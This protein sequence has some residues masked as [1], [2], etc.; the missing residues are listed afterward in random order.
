MPG[1]STAW[2]SGWPLLIFGTGWMLQACER[3]SERQ[4]PAQAKRVVSAASASARAVPT[5]A[6]GTSAPVAD[7]S[8]DGHI[9][10]ARS[11]EEPG[12]DEPMAPAAT[13]AALLELALAGLPPA[14]RPLT[15]EDTAFLK[16]AIGPGSFGSM[17]QGNPKIAKHTI[18]QRQC[19][20]RLRDVTL[21]TAA[22]RRQCQGHHLM[23]PVYEDGDPQSADVCIDV[24]EFPNR[25]CALPFVW[26]SATQAQR[27]CK[28]LGKRLCTQDEWVAACRADP[29]GGRPSNYAYGDEL[30][31]EACN[32]NRSKRDYQDDPCDPTSV[33]STWETCG[34]HTAPAGAFPRCRSR[35]GVFDLHGNVAEA[36]TRFER[37]EQ[38][39]V[40]QLKG[41]A[42]FYV[43]VHR[44]LKDKPEKA[45][46]PDHCA[47]DPRWH[48]QPM[49]RAWHVNYHLG[50][51]CCLDLR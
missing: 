39:T 19:L 3:P 50:F 4:R 46:Y 15:A 28:A 23:V 32:T 9:D 37:K 31:L 20:A 24:F 33:K 13:Q 43:D 21:Q 30:D 42:F 6:L 16:R 14:E 12:S 7:A 48:V 35:L 51:R 47:H 5:R 1:G 2:R 34:T 44:R 49:T 11:S 18:S 36:M 29:E 17:N 22:Q 26:S 8:I 45:T 27:V 38:R 25:P 40:S 41:S 10:A